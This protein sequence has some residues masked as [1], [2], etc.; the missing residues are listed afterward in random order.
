M[1]LFLNKQL[2]YRLLLVFITIVLNIVIQL[3][4]GHRSVHTANLK[5]NFVY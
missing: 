4:L 1:P 5:N 3:V 2:I